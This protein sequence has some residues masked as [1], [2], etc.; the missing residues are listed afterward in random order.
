MKTS[1]VAVF[2][3]LTAAAVARHLQ[4]R[5]WVPP[6][7]WDR[8]DELERWCKNN[9]TMIRDILDGRGLSSLVSGG[10]LTIDCSSSRLAANA[11]RMR[12]AGHM[13][14]SNLDINVPI[15]TNV[16][17]YICNKSQ[18]FIQAEGC[19]RSGVVSETR[20]R[21]HINSRDYEVKCREEPVCIRNNLGNTVECLMSRDTPA[22]MGNMSRLEYNSFMDNCH[23]Y[24]E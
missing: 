17:N 15:Y 8:C 23:Y 21:C 11:Q 18:E 20:R 7:D 12:E 13:C 22:L 6:L 5:D 4:K 14:T 1:Y 3:V 19:L 2:L 10:A 9:L 16:Y 24:I